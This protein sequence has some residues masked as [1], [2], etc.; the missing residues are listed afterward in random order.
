MNLRHP[1]T[2]THKAIDNCREA[3]A[4]TRGVC[5]NAI[6]QLLAGNTKDPYL[7]FRDFYKDLCFTEGSDPTIHLNDLQSLYQQALRGRT[8]DLYE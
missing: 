1:S 4:K 3:F 6:D 8:Q 2:E 5:R 7:A